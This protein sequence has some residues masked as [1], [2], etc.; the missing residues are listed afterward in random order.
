MRYR[1]AARRPG[2]KFAPGGRDVNGLDALGGHL[3]DGGATGLHTLQEPQAAEEGGEEA[4]HHDQ[5]GRGPQSQGAWLRRGRGNRLSH[6]PT[7]VPSSGRAGGGGCGRRR[8]GDG[9]WT[10]P[11]SPPRP[12]WPWSGRPGPASALPGPSHQ[13]EAGKLSRAA[14]RPPPKPRRP[15]T[16]APLSAGPVPPGSRGRRRARRRAPC[17]RPPPG[18]HGQPGPQELGARPSD[19]K[20]GQAGGQAESRTGCSTG[21]GR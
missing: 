12:G 21:R 3:G 16:A 8:R 7:T 2:R 11:P 17:P 19:H 20:A 6:P 14:Y 4:G 5:H 1:P 18:D 9:G 13:H 10:D 15:A